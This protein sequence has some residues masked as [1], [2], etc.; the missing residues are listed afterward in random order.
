MVCQFVG[1]ALLRECSF[2]LEDSGSTHLACCSPDNSCRIGES[3]VVGEILFVLLFRWNLWQLANLFLFHQFVWCDRWVAKYPYLRHSIVVSASCIVF[4]IL[5]VVRWTTLTSY[6]IPSGVFHGF[7]RLLG[8][9]V[10]GKISMDSLGCFLNFCYS[11]SHKTLLFFSRS[12]YS[13]KCCCDVGTHMCWA[14]V[15]PLFSLNRVCE[16]STKNCGL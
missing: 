7:R 3:A 5:I 6:W 15:N 14:D 9:G 4:P 2:F 16:A 8:S 1:R 13:L 11:V 10:L 12:L